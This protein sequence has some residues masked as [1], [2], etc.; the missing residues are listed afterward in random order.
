MRLVLGASRDHCVEALPRMPRWWS[1]IASR[2]FDL[3]RRHLVPGRRAD[4]VAACHLYFWEPVSTI[5][6]PPAT[7]ACRHFRD[8]L[9]ANACVS[10]RPKQFDPKFASC[11][12]SSTEHGE[13]ITNIAKNCQKPSQRAIKSIFKER[14]VLYLK[15]LSSSRSVK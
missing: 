1:K 8:S 14:A 5:I 4:G 6:F 10:L 15:L 3:A 7:D 13:Q 9:S 2:S 11:C 12:L